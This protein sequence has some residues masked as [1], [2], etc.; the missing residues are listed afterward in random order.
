M[1]NWPSVWFNMQDINVL[2]IIT[3]IRYVLNYKSV[4]KT[5]PSTNKFLQTQISPRIVPLLFTLGH[6]FDI[7][8]W[9]KNLRI[10]LK[11]YSCQNGKASW[12]KVVTELMNNIWVCM[13][14]D[15]TCPLFIPHPL[16][17][18]EFGS[19]LIISSRQTELNWKQCGSC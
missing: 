13:W 2:S 6:S 7:C 18:H 9:S 19:R 17:S 15:L 14:S 8:H 5:H 11:V 10:C 3:K 12:A 16:P 4:N 1:K